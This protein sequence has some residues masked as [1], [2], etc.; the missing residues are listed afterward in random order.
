MNITEQTRTG[1]TGAEAENALEIDRLRAQNAVLLQ[2]IATANAAMTSAPSW[3]EMHRSA[4]QALQ[5][6]M[7]ALDALKQQQQG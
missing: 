3:H 7:K 1:Q 5:A 2:S 6:A 4:Q